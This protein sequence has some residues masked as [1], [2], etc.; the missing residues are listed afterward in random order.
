MDDK[1][2]FFIRRRHWLGGL[3]ATALTS[4]C[5]PARAQGNVVRIGQVLPLTGPI[6]PVTR[7]LIDAQGVLI[8][9]VNA[10][11]GIHGSRIEI[12]TLDDAFDARK[13]V[14]QTR[15]LL[16][17]KGV[18]ALF[19][20]G[21][22]AGIAA[23]FPLLQEKKV[24]LIGSYTGADYL[25]ST[26]HPYYFTTTASFGDEIRQIV[27][28]LVTLQSTK[29]AVCLPES[30]VGH[31]TFTL[32]EQVMKDT[33]ATLVANRFAALDGSDAS[34]LL[35]TMAATDAHAILLLYS[36]SP[37]LAFMQAARGKLRLPPIYTFSLAGTSVFL[38]ALGPSAHGMAISQV[39]PYPWRTTTALTRQFNAAMARAKLAISYDHMHGYL[40]AV[41]L[42]EALRRAGKSPTPAS[43]TSAMEDM[44]DVD[45]GGYRL[46]YSRANHHGSHFV[47]MTM[48]GS[49]GEY[50]R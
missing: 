9:E 28:N 32:L 8:D 10:K 4:L 1:R 25:R 41:I 29:L 14:E 40:N 34:D 23:T 38:K 13:T 7:P 16:N 6:G 15:A 20:Y 47:E 3:T 30:E 11:G 45:L 36:G 39:V 31:A 17:E 12:I 5:P 46:N 26:L 22:A 2:A 42:V 18:V 48:V 43:I 24:P 49:R 37:M 44:N 21:T 50:L 27:R 35:E 33:G 19:G